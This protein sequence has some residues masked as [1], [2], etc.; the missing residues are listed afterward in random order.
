M[1]PASVLVLVG[2]GSFGNNGVATLTGTL[3]GTVRFVSS[4]GLPIAPL[5]VRLA[6][7]SI[8]TFQVVPISSQAAVIPP[9]E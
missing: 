4:A 7:D 1:R 3:D 5:V 6:G 9:V 2:M 8:S